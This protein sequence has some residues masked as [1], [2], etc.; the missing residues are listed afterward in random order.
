MVWSEARP[1]NFVPRTDLC[2]PSLL[3]AGCYRGLLEV[4]VLKEQAIWPWRRHGEPAE[5]SKIIPRITEP[6]PRQQ[7]TPKGQD[8]PL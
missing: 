1:G 5:S 3:A 2:H 7:N 6:S 8:M 4:L